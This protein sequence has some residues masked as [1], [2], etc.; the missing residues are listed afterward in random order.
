MKKRYLLTLLGL[1]LA[2]SFNAK[3]ATDEA[4]ISPEKRKV[5]HRTHYWGVSGEPYDFYK[6][7]S[8]PVAESIRKYSDGTSMREENI[9]NEYLYQKRLPGAEGKWVEITKEEF[10]G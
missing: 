8:E 5:Y 10:E 2:G 7:H 9:Q 6:A 4:S 1:S 3:A